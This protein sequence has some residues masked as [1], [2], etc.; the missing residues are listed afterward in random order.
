[1]LIDG[2]PA[3]RVSAIRV[4]AVR[5]SVGH[6]ESQ[7]GLQRLVPLMD[8]SNVAA[9]GL[10]HGREDEAVFIDADRNGKRDS[11]LHTAWDRSGR[12]AITGQTDIIHDMIMHMH[13]YR[14]PQVDL[15]RTV[16]V[17]RQSKRLCR[18]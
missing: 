14:R 11:P 3:M 18:A 15:S 12:G 4:I 2:L 16:V 9:R 10:W 7:D 6:G 17:R 8:G 1:M 13:V 5:I